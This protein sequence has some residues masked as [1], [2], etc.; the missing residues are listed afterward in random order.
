[1]GPNELVTVAHIAKRFYVDG[2]SRIEIAAELNI[3]RFKVARM[4]ELALDS[5]IVKITIDPS[6]SVDVALSL[7]LRDAFGLTRAIATSVPQDDTGPIHDRLGM[8]AAQLL[9]EIVEEDDVLG[10]TAGRTLSAMAAQLTRLPHCEVVQLAGVAGAT[11]VNGV[12]VIR[13]VSRLSGGRSRA[14]YAP[15]LVQHA[16]TAAALRRDPEVR[17]T[18]SR[19]GSVTKAVVAI[20]SWNP[21]DS[22]LYENAQRL[23]M[24]DGVLERGIVAEIGAT[25]LDADGREMDLI[26]DRSIAITSAQL[27]RVPEVIAVAGGQKKTA[28]ILAALR[29][30]LVSSLVTDAANARSLVSLAEA[31]PKR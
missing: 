8:V 10:M 24:L 25:L 21:P 4:L 22:Q 23:G 16:D 19:F 20:G 26:A 31:L 28:A 9:E 5:G 15:L 3:S 30:G 13:R 11:T 7:E 27:A 17:D 14:L 6:E 29:S 2:L 12:E 1:M 18:F